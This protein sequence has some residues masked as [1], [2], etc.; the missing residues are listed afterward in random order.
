MKQLLCMLLI[1][2]CFAQPVRAQDLVP[3]GTFTTTAYCPCYKCSEGWGRQ[4]ST[5][6]T[7]TAGHTV[8]V[9]PKVIPYGTK[10][11]IDGIVYTAEDCG[12]GVKGN[13]IDIFYDTHSETVKHGVQNKDVYLIK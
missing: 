10:V 4:T 2:S 1:A 13:H 9:D 7:A 5:G 11:M 8:A 12:G 6:A 3:L